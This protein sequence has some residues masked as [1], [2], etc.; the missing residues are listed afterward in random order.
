MKRRVLWIAIGLAILF[1]ALCGGGGL[2]LYRSLNSASNSLEAEF[3]KARS[4]GIPLTAD[5]VPEPVSVEPSRN[6]ALAYK[7]VFDE[8]QRVRPKIDDKRWQSLSTGRILDEDKAQLLSEC[9]ALADLFARAASKPAAQWSID[10]RSAA[11]SDYPVW[12]AIG[13]A[14]TV[15]AE[16]LPAFGPGEA[17][18]GFAASGHVL[19]S[20]DPGSLRTASL[21][22]I[23]MLKKI[24]EGL[25][26]GD[27]SWTKSMHE[28][29][30]QAK[31]IDPIP[32]WRTTAFLQYETWTRYGELTKEQ[33]E[34]FGAAMREQGVVVDAQTAEI[35][36][37]WNEAL[38]DAEGKPALTQYIELG[39]KVRKL[40]ERTDPGAVALQK[41]W[42]LPSAKGGAGSLEWLI[43]NEQLALMQQ[44][45][46]ILVQSEDLPDRFDCKRVSVLGQVPFTY[47]R[48]PDGFRLSAKPA[49]V[50][51]ADS[52]LAQQNLAYEFRS[53]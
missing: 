24:A 29:L 33:K 50:L 18:T 42:G 39:E 8:W 10:Y 14:A 25:P 27:R 43:A 52:P 34:T 40:R 45:L 53:K 51:A 30:D 13:D 36:K 17:R 49:P 47:Q 46:D 41:L 37:F 44:A 28:V 22:R 5:E 2:A 26:E 23:V 15:W 48:T 4:H 3:S 12:S 32:V 6:A 7:G 9:G 38:A 20:H 1:L 21:I 31:P 11:F 19:S 16:R 35:L